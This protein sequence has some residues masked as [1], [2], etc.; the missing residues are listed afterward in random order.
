VEKQ[1]QFQL[2]AI[3]RLVVGKKNKVLRSQGQIP[4]VI[5]GHSTKT[6]T[7]SVDA[8]QFEKVFS[9]AGSSALV[10]LEIDGQSPVKVLTLEPQRDPIRGNPIHIDFYKVRMDEKI[11]TEIPLEFVG[12]SEAVTQ[13]DGSLV[14]NRDSVEVECLPADLVSEIQVDISALKTFED[15]ISVKDLRVSQGIEILTDPEEVIAL[16]EEPRSEEELAE[17]ETPTAAEEEKEAIEKMGAEAEAEKA[18]GEA[19]EGETAPVEGKPESEQ[20]KEEN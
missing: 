3:S 1:K 8:R 13:L 7:L 12:E 2:K 11:K 20:P 9:E 18:E 19:V 4:A 16:V 15:S 5:Y 10:D 6:Q 17:L 14:T